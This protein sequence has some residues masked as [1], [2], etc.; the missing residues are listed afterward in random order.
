MFPQV[1]EDGQNQKV[2]LH[3]SVQ[4]DSIEFNVYDCR[5]GNER[6]NLSHIWEQFHIMHNMALTTPEYAGVIGIVASRS[7][8]SSFW[9]ESELYSEI[10]EKKPPR[11]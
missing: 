1:N 4:T 7:P 8:W 3:C 2:L 6:R 5:H 11:Y 9:L 10:F